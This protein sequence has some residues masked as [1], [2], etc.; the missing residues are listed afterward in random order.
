MVHLTE[1]LN[2]QGGLCCFLWEQPNVTLL[3]I[4]KVKNI[5]EDDILGGGWPVL[6][7]SN[8]KALCA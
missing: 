8:G 4:T 3:D 1:T 7:L 6:Q 2:I 5:S